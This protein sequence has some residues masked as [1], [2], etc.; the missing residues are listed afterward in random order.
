[1][2]TPLFCMKNSIGK[3]LLTEW[4]KDHESD[5]LVDPDA[6]DFITT[7]S[8]ADLAERID[9]ALR[10]AEQRGRDYR[11]HVQVMKDQAEH[12]P[13]WQEFYKRVLHMKGVIQLLD[14]EGIEPQ[15]N[16]AIRIRFRKP[17]LR[18]VDPAVMIIYLLGHGSDGIQAAA[19]CHK[20][21]IDLA[22]DVDKDRVFMSPMEL[23]SL[24][25]K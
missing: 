18:A 8:W 19:E 13:F 16:E 15:W 11:K 17:T 1:M 2:P 20:I 22:R 25:M 4:G 23:M 7:A 3:S 5:H 10:E 14:L 9:I 6:A 21:I 12:G 24:T